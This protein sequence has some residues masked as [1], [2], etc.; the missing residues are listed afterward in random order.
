L[1]KQKLSLIGAIISV[2]AGFLSALTMIEKIGL[3]SILTLFFSGFAGGATLV[4]LIKQRQQKK[5]ETRT[6]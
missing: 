3:A 5:F 1:N 4:N 6:S 2:L